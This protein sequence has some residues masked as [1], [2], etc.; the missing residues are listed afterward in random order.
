MIQSAS[1]CTPNQAEA[2][3]AVDA[4]VERQTEDVAGVL[5]DYGSQERPRKKRMLGWPIRP[6]SIAV[7][8][9]RSHIICSSVVLNILCACR[10]TSL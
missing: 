2:N 6:R 10:K 9:I 1:N 5:R 7:R 8:L 4:D 3:A